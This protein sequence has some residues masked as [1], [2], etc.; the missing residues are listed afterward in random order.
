[1]DETLVEYIEEVLAN[2]FGA[3]GFDVG[4]G[5]YIFEVADI[6]PNITA[7]G[8]EG[9]RVVG[10]LE[11]KPKI[12]INQKYF[13]L[14][15]GFFE[16]LIKKFPRGKEINITLAVMCL[17]LIGMEYSFGTDNID[18]VDSDITPTTVDTSTTPTLKR[19][20]VASTASLEAGQRALIMTGADGFQKPELK[21]IKSFNDVTKIVEFVQPLERLPIAGAEF[22]II[23]GTEANVSDAAP[24]TRQGRLIQFNEDKSYEVFHFPRL[25]GS[26]PGIATGTGK[27]ADKAELGLQGLKDWDVGDD[28]KISSKYFLHKRV[29]K[30]TFV[31]A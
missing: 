13:D 29:H 24:P 2:Y 25:D 23:E 21:H 17:T 28:N 27:E 4:T 6:D 12:E 3:E 22:K 31:E 11:S 7:L 15:A 9:W 18:I 20:K 1:M 14:T 8:T 10:M 26:K 30:T 16:S 19:V 5:D